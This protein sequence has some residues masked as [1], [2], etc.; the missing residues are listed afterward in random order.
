MHYYIKIQLSISKIRRNFKV[1]L[2]KEKDIKVNDSTIIGSNKVSIK[3]KT[4]RNKIIDKYVHDIRNNRKLR[5]T[6][7]MFMIRNSYHNLEEHLHIFEQQE[8]RQTLV[9]PLS[10][11]FLQQDVQQQSLSWAGFDLEGCWND[12]VAV[13]S[14]RILDPAPWAGVWFS[15]W[16]VWGFAQGELDKALDQ[17]MVCDL[18][19]H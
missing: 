18:Y 5:K 17:R 7:H 16:L 2:L 13:G 10:L 9:A 19:C 1:L 6:R 3:S 11:S 8:V 4:S 14:A 12:C 15:C